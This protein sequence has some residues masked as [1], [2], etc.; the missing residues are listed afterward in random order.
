[1]VTLMSDVDPVLCYYTLH[2]EA[3]SVVVTNVSE[4]LVCMLLMIDHC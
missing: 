4:P 1:M 3:V 2:Y